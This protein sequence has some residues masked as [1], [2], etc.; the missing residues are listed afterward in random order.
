MSAT[1]TSS[2]NSSTVILRVTDELTVAHVASLHQQL[3]S[4][5]ATGGRVDLSG[6]TRGDVF[7][8]QLL[9]ALKHT[10]AAAGRPVEIVQAPAALLAVAAAAGIKPEAFLTTL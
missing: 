9:C 1:S 10:A 7:G 3:R 4:L 8:L 5:C 6:V 2:A